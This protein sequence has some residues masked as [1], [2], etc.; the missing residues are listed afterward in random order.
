MTT[1]PVTRDQLAAAAARVRRRLFLDGWSAALLR[2]LPWLGAGLGAALILALA[3]IPVPRWSAAL[4]A[5]WPLA[6]ALAAWRSLPD[7]AGALARWDAA[8][9]RREGFLSAWH[10]LG[11]AD[12]GAFARIHLASMADRLHSDAPALRRHLPVAVRPF[13]WGGC[14]LTALILA[15]GV[16]AVVPPRGERLD[17]AQRE[18]L[19]DAAELAQREA[20]RII[21]QGLSEAE[22]RSAED[23]AAKIAAAR[24]EARSK[25][26]DDDQALTRI[27]QLAKQAEQLAAALA[28][29]APVSAALLA[30]LAAHADTADLAGALARMD[31]DAAAKL[32]AELAKRLGDASLS[33]D[34]QRRLAQAL[35]RAA[36]AAAQ[37]GPATDQAM[38][39]AQQAMAQQQPAAAAAAMAALARQLAQQGQRQQASAQVARLAQQL[40]QGGAQAVNPHAQAMRQLAQQQQ[41]QNAA[42]VAGAQQQARQALAQQQQQRPG[43]QAGQGRPGQGRPGQGRPGRSASGAGQAGPPVPGSGRGQGQGQGQGQ[44]MGTAPVPGAGQGRGAGRGHVDSTGAAPRR[45]GGRDS[46]VQAQMGEGPS[47]Q[48]ERTSDPQAEAAARTTRDTP[49]ATLAAEE[50]A[51]QA[52]QIPL[53]RREQVKAYFDLLRATLDR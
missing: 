7:A 2:L 3:G 35:A 38:R 43:G 15:A 8:A 40:R 47:E 20:E 45:S 17:A 46:T 5:L 31:L 24:E 23:L 28:A 30:E 32:A 16:L 37:A 41:R 11:Q 26:L 29:T 51:L 6:A 1:T 33:L 27:D 39:Q 25:E 52:E 9:G 13:A 19:A 10:F 14:V 50:Q 48:T 44:G 4:V 18:R 22:R 21:A 42:G 49:L 36:S 12:P 53:S 34:E